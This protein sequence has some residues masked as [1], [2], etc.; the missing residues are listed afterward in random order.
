MQCKKCSK[1]K[2]YTKFR[3]DR[4]TS[5]R[6]SSCIECENLERKNLRNSKNTP[7]QQYIYDYLL[8]HRCYSC[9]NKN[10]I[11]LDFHHLNPKEK[12]FDISKMIKN[13]MP[14]NAIK[15]EINKCIVLCANCHR[16]ETARQTMNYKYR[17]FYNVKYDS[18]ATKCNA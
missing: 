14:I 13:G 16:I 3:I 12:S 11:C 4:R 5:K 10:P 7:Q 18:K 9:G 15:H 17:N 2:H 6:R 1:Q 8:V